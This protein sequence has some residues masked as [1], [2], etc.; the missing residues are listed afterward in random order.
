MGGSR[1]HCYIA[2]FDQNM[3]MSNVSSSNGI[4]RRYNYE[5]EIDALRQSFSRFDK[6]G[7]GFLDAEE[8]VKVIRQY[9]ADHPHI[10]YPD[11]TPEEVTSMLSSMKLET[12]QRVSFDEFVEMVREVSKKDYEAWAS[13][14]FFD[15]NG[16]GHITWG[17]LKSGLARVGHLTKNKKRQK[18]VV[19]Q[20]INDADYNGD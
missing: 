11:P 9:K 10:D 19:D 7:N 4:Q 14:C 3:E 17:E 18:E 2:L 13:F 5:P 12:K 6:D 16:D 8:F 1:T 20:M 15:I